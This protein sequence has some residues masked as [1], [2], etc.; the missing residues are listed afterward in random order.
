M[1]VPSNAIAAGG[2]LDQPQQ[3]AAERR[4]AAARLADE[5]ERLA[6]STISSDRPRSTAR[7]SAS[8]CAA[9]AASPRSAST[10]PWRLGRAPV[11]A[12]TRARKVTADV[13][14]RR[15]GPA[16]GSA[17][18]TRVLDRAGS[19]PRT[20]SPPGARAAT[21]PCPGSPASRARRP[22]ADGARDRA[23]QARGVVVARRREQHLGRRA[24]S[25]TRPAYITTTSSQVSATTPR[26]CVISRTLMPSSRCSERQQ[27]E[28]LGLDRDVERG[29]RLVGDQ[30]IRLARERHRD[31]H[32]LPH[33]ARELVRV[34]RRRA[35]R[36]RGCRPGGTSRPRPRGPRPSRLVLVQPDRLGDLI[37][38]R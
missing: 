34:G 7:T 37:A 1:S 33:A 24:C 5:P 25:T 19:D 9:T 8:R 31:H 36:A 30:Q 11:I 20:C 28:D 32:A 29:R 14:R 22:G 2:R 17:L 12:G 3:R 27:L 6:A 21:A 16:R 15:A 38:R 4:L 10:A 35:P 23:Q 13:R 26:S 18:A